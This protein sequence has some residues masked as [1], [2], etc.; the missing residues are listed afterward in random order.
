METVIKCQL[1]LELQFL[2]FL[3]VYLFILSTKI[4]SHVSGMHHFIYY[5]YIIL[6]SLSEK[7]GGV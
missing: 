4:I 2:L 5:I 3:F 6:Y 7:K 1:Y